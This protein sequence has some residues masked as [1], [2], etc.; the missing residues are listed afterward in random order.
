VVAPLASV[1]VPSI[2]LF[3]VALAIIASSTLLF[4][5]EEPRHELQCRPDSL[6]IGMG[7]TCVLFL[8]WLAQRKS[9]CPL[10]ADEMLGWAIA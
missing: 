3:I 4:C 6:R 2:A 8:F 9:Y 10:D 7:I 1:I 5:D